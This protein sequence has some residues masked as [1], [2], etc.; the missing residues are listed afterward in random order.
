MFSFM[1]T[2]VGKTAFAQRLRG[3][4]GVECVVYAGDVPADVELRRGSLPC[5]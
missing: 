5:F 4:R 2:G 1:H 3:L